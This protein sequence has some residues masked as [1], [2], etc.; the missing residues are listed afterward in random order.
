MALKQCNVLIKGKFLPPQLIENIEKTFTV[1]R[2]WEAEDETAFLAEQGAD[3]DMLVTSGNAVMGAPAALIAALPNLKA[4]CSNGVGYDSIDTEAARSRGIVVTNTPEVL[5][6]CVA[7]LGMALLLDVARRISE[8]DRFTRAG[9]WSQGRF[10]LSSKIGG[11]VCG[12][13]GLGN[14]G[15]A[16]ARRAQAFDMAIHYY[17]PRSRP[18]VTYTRHESL[19]ALAQQAD[20]LVLTLPGGA[21]TRHIINAEVLQAL[22]PQGYLIN[23]AR[24]SVVDQQALVDALETGQIAGAGLDVFEQE[25]QVPDVLRQRDNVVITPHIAS[26]TR[27]TMAAMADLV[28]DNM[29][30]FARGEP[31]LTRV[32]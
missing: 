11:K 13:V 5:N 26:S 8:A 16:V 32:V 29:L 3:I 20:F 12:I 10:P 6:D 23:I 7:D 24:G 25:P 30:A 19:V 4:I 31:V 18:D 28:F 22:G 15:Q 17:N 21:A 2:L 9:H 1:F 27:E 14:I